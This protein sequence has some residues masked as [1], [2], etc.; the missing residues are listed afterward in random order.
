MKIRKAAVT[1]LFYPSSPAVLSGVVETCLKNGVSPK[2]PIPSTRAWPKAVIAPHAGF[3]Y[4]GAIAGSAFKTLAAGRK[5][6]RRVVMLGPAHRVYVTGLAASSADFFETPLGLVPV[7]K[8]AMEKLVAFPQV[9]IFDEAHAPE[10]SLETHLPFLQLALDEFSIVPLIVG[11]SSLQEV[12]QVLDALWDGDETLIA[13]SSD[14]S[15]FHSYEAAREL[16]QSTARAIE[17]LRPQDI[18]FEHACG[19]VAINGLLTVC[20][21][22]NLGATTLDLRNSGDTCGQRDRVVGYGAWAFY[23]KQ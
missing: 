11:E 3:S 8:T 23:E 2:Q 12:A 19:R 9:H 10:H 6:I 15:H 16:D 20:P 5:T 17:T 4:S 18:R 14:L 21:K 22:Y 1:E 7:D 13:V